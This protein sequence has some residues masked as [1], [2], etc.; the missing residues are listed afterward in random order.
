M[1]LNRGKDFSFT[2]KK[3][4]LRVEKGTQPLHVSQVQLTEIEAQ[5]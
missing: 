4:F 3:Y 1:Y 2:H 5:R